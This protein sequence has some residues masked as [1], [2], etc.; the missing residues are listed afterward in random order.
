MQAVGS[1]C[2][3]GVHDQGKYYDTISAKSACVVRFPMM[4][5]GESIM[6]HCHVLS[7][8]DNG[9]MTW[10]D[11]VGL[12]VTKQSNFDRDE[13]TCPGAAPTSPEATPAPATNAPTSAPVANP[14]CTA[15]GDSCGINADCCSGDCSNGQPSLRVC[16]NARLL[17]G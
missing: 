7:H 5:Y 15:T 16:L 1:G 2:G 11:V 14:S 4:D 9:S 10:V 6:M 17:R 8:E 3:G 13:K 12:D